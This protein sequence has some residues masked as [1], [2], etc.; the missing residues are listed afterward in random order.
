MKRPVY[1]V[2]LDQEGQI[3]CDKEGIP[4]LLVNSYV[5]S[6]LKSTKQ[7]LYRE[8]V[9]GVMHTL[10]HIDSASGEETCLPG[11]VNALSRLFNEQDVFKGNFHCIRA[12]LAKCSSCKVNNR[13]PMSVLPPPIAIRSYQPHLIDMAPKQHHSFMQNNKWG[14]RYILAV[15]CCFSKFCWLFP[16][17]TK[18][19]DEVYAILKTLLVKEGSPTILQSDNGGEYQ[20]KVKVV[21][22]LMILAVRVAVQAALKFK[23]RMV[24]KREASLLV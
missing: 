20:V 24:P 21:R 2:K 14:Y 7:L 4:V 1:T 9:D 18:A 10:H 16:L 11:G 13:L 19:S 5:N 23:S 8:A 15:K 17:K 12:L 6:Q 22:V 3:I